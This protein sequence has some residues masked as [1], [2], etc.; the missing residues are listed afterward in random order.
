QIFD[1]FR[2]RTGLDEAIQKA[3]DLIEEEGKD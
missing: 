1:E 2:E 3:I